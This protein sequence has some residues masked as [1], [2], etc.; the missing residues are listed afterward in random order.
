MGRFR[1]ALGALCAAAMAATGA[2]AQ[3]SGP[4][5]EG[6]YLSPD[7][8]YYIEITRC[9]P[10][11]AENF[12]GR[13]ADM[14]TEE[15]YCAR[16]PL[17]G[18]SDKTADPDRGVGPGATAADEIFVF[19]A[20]NGYVACFAPAAETT[21]AAGAPCGEAEFEGVGFSWAVERRL[22]VGDGALFAWREDGA[23]TLVG[24]PG[25]RDWSQEGRYQGQYGA[26][27]IGDFGID[28]CERAVLRPV[29]GE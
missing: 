19:S 7:E 12:C 1:G 18:L 5:I 29:A 11:E 25:P 26:C 2:A 13:R 6:R 24:C 27:D 3:V 17:A 23:I 28:A 4:A 16:I 15:L 20:T 8:A 14:P 9:R 10:R 22:G 21:R